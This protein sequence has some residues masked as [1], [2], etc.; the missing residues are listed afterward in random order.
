MG[1]GG[2][3]VNGRQRGEDDGNGDKADA[4]ANNGG[5]ITGQCRRRP[6]GTREV[7]R[8]DIKECIGDLNPIQ[9]SKIRLQNRRRSG[10]GQDTKGKGGRRKGKEC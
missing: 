6:G 10:S 8:E 3:D 7:E 1:V 4:G 9:P 2:E 5:S